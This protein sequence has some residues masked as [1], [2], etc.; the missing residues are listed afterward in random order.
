MT[1]KIHTSSIALRAIYD[2]NFSGDLTKLTSDI[3]KF[4]KAN[5]ETAIQPV[6]IKRYLGGYTK[7]IPGT[8]LNY[9]IEKISK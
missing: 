1:T 7:K 6:T 4:R 9:I 8:T 5:G 3:N 2:A